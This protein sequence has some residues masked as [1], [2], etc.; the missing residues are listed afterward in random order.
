MESIQITNDDFIYNWLPNSEE[1]LNIT[2]KNMNLSYYPFQSSES[3]YKVFDLT[4]Q[5]GIVDAEDDFI[6][7][8][9]KST[10]TSASSTK[11]KSKVVS[12]TQN[13]PSK[14]G[15]VNTKTQYTHNKLK[16]TQTI[17]VKPDWKVIG[18]FNKQ[19]LE[20][21]K[22]DTEVEVE[23]KLFAG[24]LFKISDD[25]QDRINPLNSV[26][27][28]RFENFKFF[29]NVT[30]LEDE[31]MKSANDIAQVFVTDKILS[32]IMT[33]VFSSRPWHLKIT[34]I[35]DSIFIDKM[36]NSEI[37]LITVNESSDNPPQDEDDK[38]IDSFKNLSI[39]A[40]LINEFI[41]EQIIDPQSPYEEEIEV[42]VESH[43]FSTENDT[44]IERLSYRYRLWKLGEIDVLVRC[45]V[46]AF[47]EDENGE[48]NLIN[49][50]ALNEF[51]VYSFIYY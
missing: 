36:D 13:I 7:V 46:H 12:R 25:Y 6:A 47:E 1:M 29:G 8:D 2:L 4:L 48:T 18:S 40:T 51:D 41:K 17:T 9:Q 45:Q 34:K 20:K 26:P 42:N 39:E 30:T 11:A 37:D 23:D 28:E 3:K 5:R 15:P 22:I 32:V 21:L 19:S 33:S 50:Y 24:K 44:D 49:I 16:I 31:K 10:I 14:K 43:P 38:Q 27:I 35:G